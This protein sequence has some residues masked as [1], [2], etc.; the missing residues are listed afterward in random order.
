MASMA[1]PTPSSSYCYNNHTKRNFSISHITICQQQQSQN[2]HKPTD[3]VGRREIILRSS[4]LAVVGAI[5]NFSGKKPDYL[6]VQKNQQALA[7][8]PATKNCISTAENVT[9]IVHYAPPWN[10]NGG[11][12]R[13]KP[14]SRE[15]AMEELLQVIK[16]TKP[17]KFTPRI[18]EKKDDYVRV[19]YQSSILGFVDDVEFWFPPRDSVVEYRS[20]SRLGNFDFDINRKRIKALRQELENKGWASKDSF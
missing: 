1:Y 6:G 9:D 19:E 10:Y 13:K 2:D 7:L 8:C 3:P 17:D 5:F 14:V 12:N 15:V 4:E 16:S 20:A 18:M 11:R